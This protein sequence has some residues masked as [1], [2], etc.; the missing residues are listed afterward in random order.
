[1]DERDQP[2][3]TVIWY[4]IISTSKTWNISCVVMCVLNIS[5]SE[6][7]EEKFFL[8]R[9]SSMET[10]PSVQFVMISSRHFC[11]VT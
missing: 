7:K 11:V 6:K 10:L 9:H 4:Y 2:N 1:M 5:K 8:V 3:K